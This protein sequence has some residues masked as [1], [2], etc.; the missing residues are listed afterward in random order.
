MFIMTQPHFLPITPLAS[1][2]NQPILWLHLMHNRSI[3][4]SL[5]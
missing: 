2:P 1:P 3:I 5:S 4:A